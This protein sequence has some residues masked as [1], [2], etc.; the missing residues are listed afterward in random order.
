M[1]F[2]ILVASCSGFLVLGVVSSLLG[3]RFAD[4]STSVMGITVCTIAALAYAALRGRSSE[5]EN[6]YGTASKLLH[7]ISLGSPFVGEALF[8]IEKSLYLS[9]SKEA[10]NGH[11]V[12]VCGLA[13]AGTTVLMRRLYESDQFVSLTYRDMPFVLSPN[14]WQSLNRFSQKSKELEE[15]VHGDGLLV[16]F[17]SPEALEEVFWKTKCGAD[18]ILNDSLIPMTA[19]DETIQDFRNYVSLILKDHTAHRYLSKN[20]NNIIRLTSISKAFPK[21]TV[22]VPFRQPEQQAY[23]LMRQHQRFIEMHSTDQFSKK[24]MTWLVHHEFGSDHRPFVLGEHQV[25]GYDPDNLNYWLELWLHTYS[26]LAENLA[27][28]IHLVC[29]EA[30]CED[31]DRVWSEL[32]E[33]LEIGDQHGSLTFRRSSHQLDNEFDENLLGKARLLYDKLRSQ[34]VGG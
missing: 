12:F 11:H 14:L 5:S 4:L 21:A 1:I 22:L 32:A 23:S 33:H 10:T 9:K 13:R 31:S 27:D 30:L 7:Q 2:A 20:N 15:R 26:Y 18:Y 17:D 3:G 24:Y 6:S 8:D 19:E 29:Y 25:T 28:R 16:D 34:A